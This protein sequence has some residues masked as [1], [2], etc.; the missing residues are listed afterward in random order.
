MTRNTQTQKERDAESID[1]ETLKMTVN[2]SLG[3]TIIIS[4]LLRGRKE[5]GPEWILLLKINISAL[6]GVKQNDGC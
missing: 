3:D 5:G 1:L 6:W 2:N 4:G